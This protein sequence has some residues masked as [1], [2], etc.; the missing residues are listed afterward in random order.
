MP[1]E[2]GAGCRKLRTGSMSFV[3]YP[4]N[5]ELAVGNFDHAPVKVRDHGLVQAP[6]GA[7]VELRGARRVVA[8]AEVASAEEKF[9]VGVQR[10]NVRVHHQPRADEETGECGVARRAGELDANVRSDLA[11]GDFLKVGVESE[12]AAVAP[13]VHVG[14]TIT[15]EARGAELAVD[16]GL[17]VGCWDAGCDEKQGEK[18]AVKTETTGRNSIHSDKSLCSTLR[19]GRNVHV[20]G[21]T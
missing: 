16:G 4:V 17:R 12:A 2:T 6:Q 21:R 9:R 1:G 20:L 5:L 10:D 13:V 3:G 7:P 11:E 19:N 18:D 15:V 8:V 14:H